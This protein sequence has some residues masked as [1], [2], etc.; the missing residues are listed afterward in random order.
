M[1]FRSVLIVLLALFVISTLIVETECQGRGGGGVG[2]GRDHLI[3]KR[4][5]RKIRDILLP[6]KKAMDAEDKKK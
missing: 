4:G 1:K 3:D 5:A 2:R 6:Y